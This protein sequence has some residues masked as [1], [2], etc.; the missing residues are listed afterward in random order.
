VEKCSP[1]VKSS[2]EIES[3]L[4]DPLEV[5]LHDVLDGG[6]V[7]RV[8]IGMM[9]GTP[10]DAHRVIIYGRRRK[11][12]PCEKKTSEERLIPVAEEIASVEERINGK[13]FILTEV[14]RRTKVALY[15]TSFP[16]SNVLHT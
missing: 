10:I 13:N 11:P 14:T 1:R 12:C 15:N 7:A 9:K 8:V 5:V 16:P 3:L 4:A 6:A 2:Y